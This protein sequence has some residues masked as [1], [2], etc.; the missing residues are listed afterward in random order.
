MASDIL[1]VSND[2]P[3]SQLMQME[4][5]FEGHSVLVERDSTIGF[6]TARKTQPQLLILDAA[7]PG[8]PIVEICKRL[9]IAN[10]NLKIILL[11]TIDRIQSIE[12]SAD[13]Y[14][15][16]PL[17][18]TELLLRVKLNLRQHIRER[19]RVL[20]FEDLVLDFNSHEVHRG[21]RLVK[22]PLKEFG[23]LTYLLRHPEQ[24]LERDQLLEAVWDYHFVGSHNVLHV[25]IRSLRNK[26]EAAG[27][28]RL[29][30]TVRG[31]GYMLKTSRSRC[32]NFDDT[33][34]VSSNS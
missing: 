12:L 6:L 13:D 18:L 4:L 3:M 27:E 31:V 10:A 22:L 28:P 32:S 17:R 26:L 2:E 23:L 8:L 5:S 33:A 24:V 14:I 19:A 15:F 1:I 30:Q 16:K 21:H 25:C 29:I 20:T 34:L 11:T 7:T 9:R